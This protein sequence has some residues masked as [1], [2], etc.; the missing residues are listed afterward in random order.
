MYYISLERG[1]K[2]LFKEPKTNFNF[3][4]QPIRWLY[5]LNWWRQ[6]KYGPGLSHQKSLGLVGLKELS[7]IFKHPESHLKLMKYVYIQL[8]EV[9]SSFWGKTVTIPCYFYAET[10]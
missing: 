9:L 8:F 1:T 7:Y 5:F 10:F 4:I 2:G 3:S 6:Q